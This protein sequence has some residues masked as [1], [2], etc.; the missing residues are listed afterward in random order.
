MHTSCASAA[1]TREKTKHEVPNHNAEALDISGLHGTVTREKATARRS[2][3]QH[4][5]L[6]VSR[7]IP[8]SCAGSHARATR[9]R[10]AYQRLRRT[11]E[12]NTK[13]PNVEA[14]DIS[15][16]H[17]AVMLGRGRQ[18]SAAVSSILATQSD[19]ARRRESCASSSDKSHRHASCI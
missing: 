8:E 3:Q 9:T 18:L 6:E 12:P 15:V 1:L 2:S 17:G 14:P 5:P 11:S 16:R 4:S 10:R 19:H 13:Y 7:A